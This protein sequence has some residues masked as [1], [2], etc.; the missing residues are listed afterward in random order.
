MNHQIELK[1]LTNRAIGK[2]LGSL[3][4]TISPVIQKEIKHQIRQLELNILKNIFNIGNNQ[5][6][7][8]NR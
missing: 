3:G 7:Q 8:I 1:R 2:L 4:D 5:N 6:E